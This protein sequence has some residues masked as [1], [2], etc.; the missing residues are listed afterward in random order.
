MNPGTEEKLITIN[1]HDGGL[2]QC[3][4]DVCMH[5][6]VALMPCKYRKRVYVCVCLCV[7]VSIEDLLGSKAG[8]LIL[9]GL[10]KWVDR[11]HYSHYRM[12]RAVVPSA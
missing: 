7:C 11:S 9:H 10:S 1:I 4:C 5:A 6:C 3:V 12:R 2:M 8:M